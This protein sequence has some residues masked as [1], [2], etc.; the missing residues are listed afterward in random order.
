MVEDFTLLQGIQRDL[1]EAM[2]DLPMRD[3]RQ[4]MCGMKT[5]MAVTDGFFKSMLASN[6]TLRTRIA[7]MGHVYSLDVPYGTGADGFEP[8]AAADFV[9][10]YMN[11]VRIGSAELA[12]AAPDIANACDVCSHRG[13]C[14]EA[15]GTA[16]D[17]EYG[18]YPFNEASID[19]VIRGRQAAF[20]PRDLLGVLATTLTQHTGE[21]ADGR[22][23]SAAW[24]TLSE[25][26]HFGREPLPTLSLPTQEQLETL[27]KPVQRRI[28]LTYWGG[29]PSSVVNLS[30]GV[31]E[32][33]DIPAIANAALVSAPR[34]KPI[35]SD[36][37]PTRAQFDVE[38]E[39]T[40][41]AWRDGGTLDATTARVIRR[42]VREAVLAALDGE[43][44]LYFP[45]LVDECFPPLPE[46]FVDIKNS[47]GGGRPQCGKFRIEFAATN[48]HAL[49][50]Q[51]I[52]R[53]QRSGSWNFDGG[54]RALTAFLTRVNEEAIRLRD[55]IGQVIDGSRGLR[56]GDAALPRAAS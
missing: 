48:D 18:L 21:I 29:V 5:V 17:A 56:R 41:L 46:G 53:S 45:Q 16:L 6:D 10:R 54:F 4:L 31:H 22:F 33:F 30:P 12:D 44:E 13:R 3:G 39:R 43:N 51:G 20:N 11:A 37:P 9:G 32:A 52:I 8:D 15:F 25:A 24:E 34:P 38:I 55:F 49:L 42:V 36:K 26:R 7:D 35:A 40:M 28:L 2:I 1:L 47:A 27:P 50:F 14:H 23:P 19:R